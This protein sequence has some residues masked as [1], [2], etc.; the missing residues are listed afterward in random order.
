MIPDLGVVGA[1]TVEEEVREKAKRTILA[2]DSNAH[3][4]VEILGVGEVK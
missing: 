1:V 4:I 2:H 3:D